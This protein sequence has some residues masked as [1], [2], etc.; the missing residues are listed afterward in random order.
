MKE[1]KLFC[2][3]I[4]TS[5]LIKK[6]IFPCAGMQFLAHYGKVS[7]Q[8]KTVYQNNIDVFFIQICLKYILYKKKSNLPK[9][10]RVTAV[11]H[12]LLGQPLYILIYILEV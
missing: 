6:K 7:W 9:D 10:E 12:E 3:L 1:T 8:H 4:K 5:L 2:I 11:V